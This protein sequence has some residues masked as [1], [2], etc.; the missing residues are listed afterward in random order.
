[1]KIIIDLQ[2]LQRQGNRKRGIGRYC[3]ELTK[4]L[5]NYYPENEYI[6]FTNSSLRDLRTD[7]VD[8]LNNK[9]IS[10]TY[11]KCPQCGQQP[12]LLFSN[13]RLDP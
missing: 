5:I 11:F 6:L 4:E 1:M 3:L 7:F 12:C 8:E 2:G 10:L 9:N 13:S